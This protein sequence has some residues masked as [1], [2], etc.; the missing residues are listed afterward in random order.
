MEEKRGNCGCCRCER[1]RCLHCCCCCGCCRALQRLLMPLLPQG[2]GAQGLREGRNS[3]TGQGPREWSTCTFLRRNSGANR[4]CDDHCTVVVVI[5]FAPKRCF[6]H[7]DFLLPAAIQAASASVTA[8]ALEIKARA[9]FR[10]SLLIILVA[11]HHAASQL[12]S[13][14]SQ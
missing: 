10:N 3:E 4:D 5:L 11:L 2:S 9:C 7:C 14:P 8:H 1:A 6:R 12:G 13:P